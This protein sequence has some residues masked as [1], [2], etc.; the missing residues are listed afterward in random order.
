MNILKG[1]PVS[2]LIDSWV[3]DQ[4]SELK[5]KGIQPKLG[6]IRVGK[7]EDDIAYER[8]VLNKCKKIGMDYKVFEYEESISN[9]VFQDAI[10]EI[11]R[12]KDVHGILMFRPLPGNI[13]QEHVT[14]LFRPEKDIDGILPYNLGSVLM[15]TDDS[16]AP[17]TAESVF[18]ILK[19]YEVPLQGSNVAIINCS[20]VVGK[21][22]AMMLANA[23]ATPTICHVYTRDIKQILH[24]SDIIVTAI[25]KAKYFTKE[26]F[27]RGQIVIDVGINLDED[28]RLCGDVDF[29]NVVKNAA[30]ISPVPGGV[31]G[32]TTS[33]LLRNVIRACKKSV[34]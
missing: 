20:N 13:D 24:R 26:Y 10:R 1:K 3:A 14:N 29:D 18:E 9:K 19:H 7:R 16:F 27:R 30:G 23:E 25:G 15:G 21:P 8:S 4:I 11:N 32:V 34:N 2:E 33:L 22:L 31:G 17:C 12:S 28:G 6:I 5:E